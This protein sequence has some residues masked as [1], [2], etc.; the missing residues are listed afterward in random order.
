MKTGKWCLIS[1]SVTTIWTWKIFIVLEK[2][3]FSTAVTSGYI[4]CSA[5]SAFIISTKI[6]ASLDSAKYHTF[7]IVAVNIS[8]NISSKFLIY[9][10]GLSQA[11]KILF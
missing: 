8:I 1:V 2:P 6:N 11:L 5:D 4:I 3:A 9:Y 7:Q 10:P